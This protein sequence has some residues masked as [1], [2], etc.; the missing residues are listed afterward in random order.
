M[1]SSEI[2]D[3]PHI[4]G[5]GN[6]SYGQQSAIGGRNGPDVISGAKQDGS[7]AIERYPKQDS[8]RRIIK[9]RN[10]EAPSIRGPVDGLQSVPSFYD[11]LTRFARR[12][13]SELDRSAVVIS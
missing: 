3:L 12:G 7:S 5:V 6:L 4:L 1:E 9:P 11:Q 10:Q 13:G 2:L 8:I